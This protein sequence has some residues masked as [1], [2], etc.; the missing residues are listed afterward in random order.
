MLV[1]PFVVMMV[2]VDVVQGRGENRKCEQFVR[3]PVVC[4]AQQA[5]ERSTLCPAQSSLEADCRLLGL[6]SYI[7]RFPFA[8]SAAKD[9]KLCL[10]LC[11]LIH[12]FE[13]RCH[14]I[15]STFL[16]LAP[17]HPDIT[18]GAPQTQQEQCPHASFKAAFRLACGSFQISLNI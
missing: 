3:V 17:R 11:H 13:T 1:S 8:F 10:L 4:A 18:R 6:I 14:R 7:L 5:S 2:Y 9:L 15:P 12:R 16:V